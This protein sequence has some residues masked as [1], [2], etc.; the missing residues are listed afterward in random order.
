[1]ADTI[2]RQLADEIMS[3]E[4]GLNHRL[5]EADL[6]ERFAV[7]RT[8]I[9]EALRQL[10]ATGLIQMRPRRSAVVAPVDMDVVSQGYEAAAELEG[11]AAG[12][13][14]TRSTLSERNELV[15]LNDECR[16]LVIEGDHASFAAANLKFHN[17]IASMAR[18]ESL[19]SA[20][21]MVRVQ[22]APYQRVQFLSEAERRQSTLDH[23][24]IVEAIVAM[25]A[26]AARRE[27]RNHIL[28][29]GVSAVAQYNARRTERLSME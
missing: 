2:R 8:P 19:A 23:D 20:T 21:M 11:V 7:S 29:A 17:K 3:G 6:A 1:M 24:Q 9:R 26:E 16:Q 5:D 22:I 12:W 10:A 18:N 14:A 13:A 28:R 15:H 27:M 4:L 25:D